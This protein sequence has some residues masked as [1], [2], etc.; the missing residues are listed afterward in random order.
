MLISAAMTMILPT[1][2][3]HYNWPLVNAPAASFFQNVHPSILLSF[4]MNFAHKYVLFIKG[5]TLDD[6]VEE[7]LHQVYVFLMRALQEHRRQG[8]NGDYESFAIELLALLQ[9]YRPLYTTPM[10]EP[11]ESDFR[12]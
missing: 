12:S 2:K 5:D 1:F 11:P 7:G 6:V 9:K 3:A 4:Y 10:L 8:R